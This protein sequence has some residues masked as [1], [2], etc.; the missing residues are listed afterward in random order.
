MLSPP[1]VPD[2]S[3]TSPRLELLFDLATVEGLRAFHI[4]IVVATTNPRWDCPRLAHVGTAG[5]CRSH[6]QPTI[7]LTSTHRLEYFPI[8]FLSFPWPLPS[9]AVVVML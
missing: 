7:D 5:R 4:W 8:P 2:A 1:Q 9:I 3:P 6:L